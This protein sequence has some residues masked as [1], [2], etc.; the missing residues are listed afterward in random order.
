[1]RAV[2]AQDKRP[3]I[4]EL[5]DPH[6]KPDDLLIRVAATALNRADLLQVAGN[7]PPPPDAPE[8]LGLEL[9]GEVI[10]MG[11]EVRGYKIGQRVMALVVGGAYAEKAAVNAEYVMPIPDNLTDEQAAALPE[12]FLTAYSNMVEI[13]GLLGGETVLIHAGA[14]GVGLAAIQIAKLIGARVAVTAS[15]GKHALCLEHGAEMAFDYHRLNFADEL[16]KT[17]GGAD[18]VLDMVGAAYWEDNLRVLNPWGRLVFVGLMGGATAE[19]NFGQIMRKRLTIT[20]STLRDR[21]HEQKA[22]LVGRFWK[23]AAPHFRTGALRPTVWRHFPLAQ[24]E[25]AHQMM[26]AN[27]NAGKIV[28]R[29]E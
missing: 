18:V 1:M 23:W 28:L 27:Q 25:E 20:G 26:A 22:G 9:A 16:L 2:I 8:T 6:P 4:V 14:S 24:V 13:G 5:P 10:G 29:I 15:A 19:V 12:A 3:V 11:D 21:T 17:G 7:Y